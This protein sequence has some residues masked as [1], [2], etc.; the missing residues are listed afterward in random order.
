[1]TAFYAISVPYENILASRFT[2]DIFAADLWE[3][4]RR[5]R[6]CAR[7]VCRVLEDHL[8]LIQCLIG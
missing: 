3:V 6:L 7:P 4:H 5:H 8:Y 1:M 2:M